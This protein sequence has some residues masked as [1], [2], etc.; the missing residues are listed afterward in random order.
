MEQILI[1]DWLKFLVAVVFSAISFMIFR[2]VG[3]EKEEAM[4]SFQL[5]SDKVIGEYKMLLAGNLLMV[6]TM[7]I[8]L[9]QG[10]TGSQTIL[11]TGKIFYSFYIAVVAMVL[12]R[13]VIRF[14]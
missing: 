3:L 14:K 9:Y 5:N 2:K 11:M 8:Y 12:Y 13:W 6:A 7:G 10:I 1:L 4:S